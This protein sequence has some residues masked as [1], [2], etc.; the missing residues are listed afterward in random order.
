MPSLQLPVHGRVSL[1][2]VGT[3]PVP[4]KVLYDLPWRLRGA[5]SGPWGEISAR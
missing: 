2:L 3:V 4:V 1:S 5:G